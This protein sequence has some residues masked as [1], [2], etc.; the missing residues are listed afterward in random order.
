M[1]SAYV[2][3]VDVQVVAILCACIYEISVRYIS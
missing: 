2:S 3:T 1:Y